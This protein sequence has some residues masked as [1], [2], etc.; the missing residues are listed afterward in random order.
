MRLMKKRSMRFYALGQFAVVET[1]P[2]GRC[3]GAVPGR[4]GDRWRGEDIPDSDRTEVERQ[5]LIMCVAR[6]SLRD[7]VLGRAM[8][9]RTNLLEPPNTPSSTTRSSSSGRATC[10]RS[11][12]RRQPSRR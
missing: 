8:L 5:D 7:S 6:G 2:D 4:G 9:R 10:R 12:P 11:S 3:S 1:G